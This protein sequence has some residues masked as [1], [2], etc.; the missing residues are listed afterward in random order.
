M[1][2]TDGKNCEYEQSRERPELESAVACKRETEMLTDKSVLVT[3]GTGS[4]G[5]ERL[6]DNW[7]GV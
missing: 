7:T 3:G 5:I 6:P 1:R 4:F 2:G